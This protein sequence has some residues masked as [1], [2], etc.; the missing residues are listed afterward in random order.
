MTRFMTQLWRPP[1]PLML[2]VTVIF[3][4]FPSLAVL[5]VGF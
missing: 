3:A 4:V 1:A 5:R 2:L